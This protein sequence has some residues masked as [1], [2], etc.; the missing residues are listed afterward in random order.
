MWRRARRQRHLWH[1]GSLLGGQH[2]AVQQGEGRG[3]SLRDEPHG[4]APLS[5]ADAPLLGGRWSLGAR[6]GHSGGIRAY[7][8]C[9]QSNTTGWVSQWAAADPVGLERDGIGS[10]AC[11]GPSVASQPF[12]LQ[13]FGVQATAYAPGD[14]LKSVLWLADGLNQTG[15]YTAEYLP[16]LV[17]VQVCLGTCPS[18]AT[19][20]ASAQTILKAYAGFQLSGTCDLSQTT[21]PL[22]WP[23][24]SAGGG[25]PVR[26]AFTPSLTM[27]HEIESAVYG[28]VPGPVE[29][30]LSRKSCPPGSSYDPQQLRCL[31]CD[32]S[33]Y[34]LDPDLTNCEHC[35]VGGGCDGDKLTPLVA[36]SVF[37]RV[38]SFLRL[39]YCPPGAC[40][41]AVR[42][43]LGV[44]ASPTAP[45]VRPSVVCARALA[46]CVR[47]RVH[48][49]RVRVRVCV[50]ARERECPPQAGRTRPLVGSALR[51][52]AAS[53]HPVPHLV[54]HLIVIF[55]S[56]KPSPCPSPVSSCPRVLHVT[57]P[58][59]ASVDPP[60]PSPPVVCARVCDSTGALFGGERR[61]AGRFPSACRL[62]ARVPS[63]SA[64]LS[65]GGPR[66]VGRSIGPC[67]W[68]ACGGGATSRGA[69]G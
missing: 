3:G 17:T 47:A 29:L 43:V 42:C 45:P 24:Q 62:P 16:F 41:R 11:F 34:V 33:S 6:V 35:P 40:V 69:S 28:V 37:E 1:G 63:P 9:V 12:S 60:P 30:V 51:R 53:P 18:A 50:R 64:C 32:R 65:R 44:S 10:T 20:T 54:A 4:F 67:V 22:P 36:G 57:P 52:P 55:T 13:A 61:G 5:C 39:T 2:P 15:C 59:P 27:R 26:G 48:G 7:L 23:L 46:L 49:V 25:P 31:P 21:L 68:G 8:A 58:A 56:S 38:G 19:R 14:Q 66:S